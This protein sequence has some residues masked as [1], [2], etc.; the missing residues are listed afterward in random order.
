MNEML[1]KHNLFCWDLNSIG[2]I[3]EEFKND[4]FV[5]TPFIL[6]YD[7]IRSSYGLVVPSVTSYW[8]GT[9]K[10]TNDLTDIF[11]FKEE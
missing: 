8:G 11:V 2:A 6:Q 9:L 1:R 10:D 5:E 7:C 4:T 3:S